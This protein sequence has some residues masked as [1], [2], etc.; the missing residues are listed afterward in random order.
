MH[1]PGAAARARRGRVCGPGAGAEGRGPGRAPASP[2]VTRGRPGLRTPSRHVPEPRRVPEPRT[3]PA[4]HRGLA[5]AP[6][7]GPARAPR[8]GP[9]PRRG[10]APAPRTGPR[11]GPRTPPRPGLRTPPHTGPGRA[12]GRCPG[13]RPPVRRP[14]PTRSRSGLRGCRRRRCRGR[15]PARSRRTACATSRPRGRRASPPAD[16]CPYC[17]PTGRPET[18]TSGKC[19]P[20]KGSAGR[21]HPPREGR[22]AD[23]VDVIGVS[24]C[25]PFVRS[26]RTLSRSPV[27]R[28]A[29]HRTAYASWTVW[30]TVLP[31]ASVNSVRRATDLPGASAWS[32]VAVHRPP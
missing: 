16:S 5:R 18:G 7:T 12:P 30:T 29:V 9:D 23:P 6:R 8:T 25:Q 24:A 15:R 28:T 4:P 11:T 27:Q 20:G 14:R 1:G 22:P 26:A 31:F 10:P 2:Q 21:P 13:G 3:G 17:P 19:G 32:T